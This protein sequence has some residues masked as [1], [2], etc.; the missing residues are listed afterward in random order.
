M[1]AEEID[2]IKKLIFDWEGI[3]RNKF[4]DANLEGD[5]IGKRFIEHGAICYFNCAQ[6]LK[7][8]LGCQG[9]VVLTIEEERQM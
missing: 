2:A 4:I 7:K 6:E 1:S 3:A 5:E 9:L 8:A